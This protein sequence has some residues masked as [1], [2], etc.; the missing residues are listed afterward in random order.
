MAYCLGLVIIVQ[1]TTTATETISGQ[2]VYD[3]HFRLGA[4]VPI[5]KDE[6]KRIHGKTKNLE[7]EDHHTVAIRISLF[8]QLFRHTLGTPPPPALSSVDSGTLW[9]TM[10]VRF[11]L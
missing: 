5:Y 4:T 7:L 6:H 9:A 2:L 8:V 10:G 3:L 1:Y 11:C